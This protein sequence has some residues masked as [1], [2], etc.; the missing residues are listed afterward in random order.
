[1]CENSQFDRVMELAR[2]TGER[3]VVF[4]RCSDTAMVLMDL[5]D[6]EELLDSGR[7]LEGMSEKE[8]LGKI[9]KEIALW[10]ASNQEEADEPDEVDDFAREDEEV[11]AKEVED[12]KIPSRND[13]FPPSGPVERDSG[14]TAEGEDERFY[15]EPVE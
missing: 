10:R 14:E 3:V 4:D 9:D 15:L 8:M 13:D 11:A 1:M 12:Y 2:R 6:Y 7:S 5:D